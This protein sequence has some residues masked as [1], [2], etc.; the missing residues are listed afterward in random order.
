MPSSCAD[1]RDAAREHAAKIGALGRP[2][3]SQPPGSLG[4]RHGSTSRVDDSFLFPSK[5]PAERLASAHHQNVAGGRRTNF[6]TRLRITD[7]GRLVL[8]G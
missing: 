5:L 1:L 8:A 6:V 4:G 3:E 2:V 7:L